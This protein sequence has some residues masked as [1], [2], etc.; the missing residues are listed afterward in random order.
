MKGESENIWERIKGEEPFIVAEIGKNFIQTK[1][2]QSRSEYLRRAKELVDK[3]VT[4]GADAVKFQTHHYQDEQWPMRIVSPHFSGAD[5]YAWVKRNTIIT[6]EQWWRELKQYCEKRGIIFFSTP[7]SRGAASLLKKIGI[8][9]WKIGSGDILDF[10]M[11]DYIREQT[12]PIIMSTGMSSVTDV[13]MAVKY[14]SLK[15]KRLALLHC[16]SK[17]PCPVEDLNVNTIMW[18][19]KRY[20]VPVGFSDHSIG[21]EGVI[22]AVKKGAKV[23]EKHFSLSRRLWGSD[24]KVSLNPHEFEKM[25]KAVRRGVEDVA[26]NQKILGNARLDLRDRKS[27]FRGFFRKSLVTLKQIRKG[28]VI[29]KE[30]V[31]AMRP[32]ANIKGLRSEKY[33]EVVGKIAARN[34]NKMEPLTENSTRKKGARKR[35]TRKAAN[36]DQKM[37]TINIR[38]KEI[39]VLGIIP[40]RGG[41]RGIKNKNIVNLKGQPLIGYTIKA[42]QEAKHKFDWL[43]STDD[44]KIKKVAQALGAPVPYLRPKRL[45]RDKTNIIEV[46]ED[47][48]RRAEKKYDYVLLLQPTAPLRRAQ[49]IDAAITIAAGG[50][51]SVC[52]FTRVE[53]YHPWYMYYRM[54][55]NRIQQVVPTRAGM[56]RQKFPEALWRNGAIYLV[57]TDY[58]RRYHKFISPDCHTYIMPAERSVNIDTVD[59]LRLAEYYLK[60]NK[61]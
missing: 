47:A 61:K 26:E 51:T 32:Q 16:V 31:A 19:Q 59:D 1:K 2:E 27:E 28:Q 46:I 35:L 22:Q 3:A 25:V 33:P 9:L 48:V 13:D 12:Q 38:R 58:L 34:I 6:T 17:Y 14:I 30:W 11:L 37:K 49:D 36:A 8:K 53:S 4:A 56:P 55:R 20:R 40:A 52:S 45:A 10:V 54:G 15:N 43:V 41:S 18:L 24:H 60:R 50:V 23:I 5:R 7:M 57:K 39:K 42:V 44:L 29:K 21:Y